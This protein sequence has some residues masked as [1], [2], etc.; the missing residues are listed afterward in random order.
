MSKLREYL[1]YEGTQKD[2][3][4]KPFFDTCVNMVLDG[5][6]RMAKTRAEW[7]YPQYDCFRADGREVIVDDVLTY[8]L[9]KLVI[10]E[11]DY[12]KARHFSELMRKLAGFNRI[13]YSLELW[14]N[15]YL[16]DPYYY[17][18]NV[19]QGKSHLEKWILKPDETHD[20]IQEGF[21]SSPAMLPFA[22]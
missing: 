12:E 14:V 6:A 5:T 3:A 4:L 11:F 18:K 20:G 16:R 15:H 19:N 1:I 9:R 17:D 21:S 22:I 8:Y 2:A 10:E 13:R 7:N